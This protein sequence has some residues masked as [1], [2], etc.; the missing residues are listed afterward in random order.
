MDF[1]YSDE[2]R[3]LA[4]ILERL[5][6]DQEGLPRVDQH[7]RNAASSAP[8]PLWRTF[9][10]LGLLQLPFQEAVGGLG[11]GGIDAMI[12]MQSL[13]KGLI[14]EPYLDALLLPGTLLASLA[15]D[16]QRTRWLTPLLSGECR[17]ALAWQETE[18]RYDAHDIAT[19]AERRA[20]G[21]VLEGTKQVV[22]AAASAEALLITARLATGRLGIFLVPVDSD[23]LTRRDYQTLDGRAACDIEFSG[24][25]LPLDACLSEDAGEALDAALAL[26]R[27]ALC[28]EAVGSMQIACEQ[29]L[30]F[31]KERRQFG[32]PLASFQVLQHRMVDMHLNLEQARSM[33]ILAATSLERPAGERDYRI[34]A[35]KAYCGEAARFIA[36]QAIQLHG[37]MGMTDECS[38]S[39]YA[40]RLMMFDHY[41]GDVD[42]H[43]EFVSERL[44]AA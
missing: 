17:L 33:A 43:L 30:A 22:L 32:Q 7:A 35:A 34:A 39:H 40:K 8:S 1:S 19:R 12:V 16:E 31:L 13:G 25:M 44:T 27:S 29:T 3:M 41:L 37:A 36:E 9:A 23:A 24:I 15:N 11:G 10:E 4:D 42:H 21:W 20:E 2:Q 38:I 26:G 6:A 5:I 14:S 28:A 18:A